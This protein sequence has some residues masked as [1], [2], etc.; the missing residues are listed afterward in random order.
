MNVVATTLTND[1]LA[2]R[3][4]TR[5]MANPLY[6][7]CAVIMRFW[8]FQNKGTLSIVTARSRSAKGQ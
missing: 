5:N 3:D 8:R 7:T 4:L 6:Y 1:S 2:K